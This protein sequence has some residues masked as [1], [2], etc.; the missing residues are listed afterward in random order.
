[1][2]LFIASDIH[3]SAYFTDLLIDRFKKSG[4]EKLLLLGDI[5]YHG[6]RNDLPREYDPKRVS[7]SLNKIA[8]K[9]FAVR[10]NCESEVDSMVL[11]FNTAS[12]YMLYSD[13]SV[14]L[15]ATHGH[16]SVPPMSGINALLCGHT[17]IPAMERRNGYVYI[18]PGSVSIPKEASP[19]SYL[20]LEN[21]LFKWRDLNTEE[22]Y[23]EYSF[24]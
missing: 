23:M 22:T 18:N 1:M 2:K 4:A 17:H 19:H 5:L 21:G 9:I 12:D 8:D 13:G 10:G 15:C 24:Q 7:L 6:P 11:D 20:T 3:G 14:S 16:R